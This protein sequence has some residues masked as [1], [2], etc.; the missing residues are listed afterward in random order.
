MDGRLP[1]KSMCKI[2]NEAVTHILWIADKGNISIS[3]D[4][5]LLMSLPQVPDMK[6]VHELFLSS[7]TPN[8]E[9]V[10]EVFDLTVASMIRS[11][12]ITLSNDV[13]RPIWALNFDG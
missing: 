3:K 12:N 8:D 6:H 2:K 10:S 11:M 5:W 4:K 13:D 7:D 1:A 9:M